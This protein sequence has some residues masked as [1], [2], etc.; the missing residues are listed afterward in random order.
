M[1]SGRQERKLAAVLAT[2]MVG[3]SR[4]ME[5]DEAGTI[6]RQRAHRAELIDPCI[7]RHGGRIVK[8]TGD[9]LLADFAS[10]VDAVA[11]AV[12][13]QQAIV[14][15][16]VAIDADRRI[17]YRVGVN[18]GDIV[19]EGNDIFGDGVNVAA[20][21]ET[22]CEPAGVCISD[23]V[24][25]SIE[26]RLDC[27]FEDLGMQT[28][29]NISRPVH[30]W[31]W[32]PDAP[33]AA[34]TAS[35]ADNME[36]EIRFCS[37]SDGA[38]IAYAVAGSGPPLVKAPNWMHHLEYDWESPMWGHLMRW[39]ARDHTLIRFDQRMNGLSDWNVADVSFEL[40]LD[41]LAAVV[42]AN[43]LDRFPLLGVSQGCAYSIAYAAR[44]PE[45]VSRLVLYG[46]F[47]KGAYKTGSEADRQ[48]ADMHRQMIV[49][50]WG[51]NNPAFRQFF[52]S[53]FM[54]GATKEQMDWFNELQ[55]IT[56]S[57]ENA[58]RTR[59]VVYNI[60]VTEYLP[61]ITVPTLVLHCR[62]DG[63]VSF[64]AGR[65]MAAM[66]PNARFAALEGENHLILE[67][68]PAWPRFRDEVAR[69]LAEDNAAG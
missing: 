69:F 19:I 40:M 11:C 29:K 49:Q 57:P 24:H 17:R 62:Q 63:I 16:E 34:E 4:L 36:Q 67:N 32:R 14:E 46:G 28:L 51:Q 25:Q 44:H 31:Q 8:T 9:G 5:A 55:K 56:I 26:G 1:G 64:D 43:K 20:R 52:T 13:I 58:G 10:V 66:I 41:D 12:E 7:D 33:A 53:L 60:D 68:E 6:D 2:D 45:R 65:R 39:L 23:V 35:Q 27:A 59:D 50:G 18:L 22:L 21:L 61:Q 38:Q 37:S 47:A 15:K 54:P 42:D 30:A 48:T 3:Y